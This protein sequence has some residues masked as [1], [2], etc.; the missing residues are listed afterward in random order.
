MEHQKRAVEFANQVSNQTGRTGV[1]GLEN[2]KVSNR[3]GATGGE[4]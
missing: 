4:Q 3:F 2:E 1:I